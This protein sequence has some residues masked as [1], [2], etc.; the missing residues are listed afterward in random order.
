MTRTLRT[1][2]F[3]GALIAGHA[4][5]SEATMFVLGTDAAGNQL[6]YDQT[7]DITWYDYSNS[8]ENWQNQMDWAASLEVD[9]G[10]MLYD[11]WRLPVTAVPDSTCDFPGSM[12]FACRGSEMGWLYYVAL[13]NAKGGPLS[14][15]FVDG[16]SGNPASFEHLLAQPYFSSTDE[17]P[18]QPNQA[19]YFRFDIGLQS[20]TLKASSSL[21]PLIYGLALRPGFTSTAASDPEPPPSVPAPEPATWLLIGSGLAAAR[22]LRLPRRAR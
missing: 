9:F 16:Y 7:L 10:G 2:T 15:S 3:M 14:T 6:I 22:R 4:A 5:T 18:V 19:F 11:D 20:H 13:N 8:V 21:P 17:S 1:L 12:G